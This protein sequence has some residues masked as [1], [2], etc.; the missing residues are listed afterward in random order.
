MYRKR[1]TLGKRSRRR[2]V[3][4]GRR[5]TGRSKALRGLIKRTVNR[6]S[7]VKFWT[8]TINYSGDYGAG[9]TLISGFTPSVPQGTG[10]NQRI[11]CKITSRY[12]LSRFKLSFA[13]NGTTGNHGT[14][15]V[16]VI[17]GRFRSDTTQAPQ[18]GNIFDVS[19]DPNTYFTQANIT[20]KLFKPYFD[21]VYTMTNFGDYQINGYHPVRN[22]KFA[23]KWVKTF[24]Y[25]GN[26]D[27]AVGDIK[28]Y[29]FLIVC[30]DA[31]LNY[32][33]INVVGY[34]RMSYTDL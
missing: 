5:R 29:P 11:G 18:P 16:R 17:Y 27:N 20:P 26:N 8:G 3:F 30:T 4:R 25:A 32:S 7:E 19:T 9:N 1:S 22:F 34:A 24:A 21:K 10:Q 23:H 15:N 6:M 14:Y 31:P 33:T 13:A 12:Y 28:M 2:R